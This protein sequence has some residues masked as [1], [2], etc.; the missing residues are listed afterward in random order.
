M[1]RVPI[2]IATGFYEDASKPIASQQC[3]NW[4]PVIPET[5]ALSESQLKGTE[6]LSLFATNGTKNNRGAHVMNSI[7]FFV[8]GNNLYRVNS[9]GTS[10]D[11]G[12]ISG[13]GRVSIADNG[14]Q[15]C[16]VVPGSTGY[17]FT[18]S[19]DTLTEITD[20]DFFSLGPSNQVVYKDSFFVHIASDK[21]F[22]SALNDGLVYDALD[23]GTAEVDPDDNT[24]VHVNRNILYIGGNETIEPFQNVGGAGFPYQR[25]PGAVIQ[26]GIKAKFSVVEFDNS[27]VF[28]GGGKTEQPAIWRFT[29]SSAVKIS[30]QAIDNIISKESD[31]ALESVFSTTHATDG[32]Y[33]VCFHFS[34]TTFCYDATASALLGKPVWHERQSRDSLGSASR[35]RAVSSVK[36]YGKILV[37]DRLSGRVGVLDKDATNEYGTIIDR[38]ASTGPLQNNGLSFFISEIEVT[39]ESGVGNTVDPGQDPMISL[40]ISKNGGYTYGNELARSLGKKGEYDAR[41]RWRKM[42]GRVP[43]FATFKISVSDEVTPVIIKIEA[44]IESGTQ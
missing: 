43:R 24:A 27:F 21:F 4:L 41:Q 14:T 39:T 3:I 19:P 34:T 10:D 26:K 37:G 9:D 33:L 13:T 22:I 1:P 38:D 30:T 35:W 32:R 11:L 31:S 28:L 17:I 23:F 7:A 6:G 36:A 25:I 15:L 42:G 40:S 5:N 16:I 29:G 44:N 18:D 8:N 2:P 12:T 20:P